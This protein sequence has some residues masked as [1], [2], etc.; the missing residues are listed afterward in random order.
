MR[1]DI[2]KNKEYY[3]TAK[4]CDCDVCRYFCSHIR[5]QHPDIAAYLDTMNVDI[6]KP[7]EL[8]WIENDD[9]GSVTFYGCQYAVF[10]ECEKDFTL[11]IGDIEFVNNTDHHPSTDIS[12]EHFVIDFGE[13]KMNMEDQ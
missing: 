4:P 8:V 3:K 12:E 6:E 10:G 11:K 1:A 2:N 13:I 9:N 5:G 7:L